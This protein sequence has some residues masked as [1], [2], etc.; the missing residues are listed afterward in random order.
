MYNEEDFISVDQIKTDNNG[1]QYQDIYQVQF[2]DGNIF[3]TKV[4]SVLKLFDV[5]IKE[6]QI[7][8]N[9]VARMVGNL[10]SLQKLLDSDYLK[11]VSVM[12]YKNNRYVANLSFC[13]NVDNIDIEKSISNREHKHQLSQNFSIRFEMRDRNVVELER[14]TISNQDDIFEEL[15]EWL[16]CAD[17]I[18]IIER[19]D[20]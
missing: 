16:F 15:I 8:E 1:T 9:L 13:F 5:Q 10:Y 18:D 4:G 3:I 20:F 7:N 6:F 11:I 12:I 17:T 2:V 19:T 14:L